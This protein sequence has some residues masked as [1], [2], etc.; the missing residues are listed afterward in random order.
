MLLHRSFARFFNCRARRTQPIVFRGALPPVLAR[1]GSAAREGQ[2]AAG[3]GRSGAAR[4]REAHAPPTSCSEPKGLASTGTSGE[5][6]RAAS[7]RRSRWRRRRAPPPAQL[8]RQ[9]V[10]PR[11]RQASSARRPARPASPAPRGLGPHAAQRALAVLARLA[12][13]PSASVARTPAGRLW[14]I[15]AQ[16]ARAPNVPAP[17]SAPYPEGRS[18][19]HRGLSAHVGQ[20]ILARSRWRAARDSGLAIPAPHVLP[21]E[22]RRPP[23]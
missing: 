22:L 8:H 21:L 20:S 23:S 11:P 16:H 14:G 19:D 12:I 18:A 10:D 4:R 7:S 13:R 9:V 5:R 17:V 3:R 2:P 1:R 6:R 15:L